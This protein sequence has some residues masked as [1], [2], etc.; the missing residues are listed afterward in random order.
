[1]VNGEWLDEG[2]TLTVNT[3]LLAGPR[4][5]GAMMPIPFTI[6]HSHFPLVRPGASRYLRRAPE[7]ANHA[8]RRSGRV[9]ECTALEMR[10]AC[11]GIGGSNPSFSAI[12]FTDVEVR[13]HPKR[14]NVHSR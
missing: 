11:K 3:Y 5:I 12:C 2:M 8:T 6:H 9:V 1:M 10:H 7:T 14:L 4:E 13:D